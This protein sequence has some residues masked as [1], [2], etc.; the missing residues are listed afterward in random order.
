MPSENISHA[1]PAP[2]SR[3]EH[4]Q[5][6]FLNRLNPATRGAQLHFSPLGS[7]KKKAC[8]TLS[9]VLLAPAADRARG[10]NAKP[11]PLC[12]ALVASKPAKPRVQAAQHGTTAHNSHLAQMRSIKVSRHQCESFRGRLSRITKTEPHA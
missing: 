2:L 12:T 5:A 8:M 1:A 7:L 9:L 10:R 6:Q 4:D 3:A 11:I